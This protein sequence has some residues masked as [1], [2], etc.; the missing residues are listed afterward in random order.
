MT[1]TLDRDPEAAFSM[2]PKLLCD[3]EPGDIVMLMDRRLVVRALVL[4]CGTVITSKVLDGGRVAE[5]FV[6]LVEDATVTVIGRK[7]ELTHRHA[8]AEIRRIAVSFVIM[9]QIAYQDRLAL[10]RWGVDKGG[11][12]P[13]EE[14]V[15]PVPCP[16]LEM[17]ARECTIKI[18]LYRDLYT[19]RFCDK[20]GR[21]FVEVADVFH[22]GLVDVID[23]EHKRLLEVQDHEREQESANISG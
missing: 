17:N 8:D 13:I 19:V 22:D 16:G 5:G 23:A 21:C 9:N 4:E 12:T 2:T 3:C 18:L 7:E 1:T 15:E 20:N 6:P 10:L 11:V 14:I